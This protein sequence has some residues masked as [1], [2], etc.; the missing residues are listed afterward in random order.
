M[1]PSDSD[2]SLEQRWK[3]EVSTAS[4]KVRSYT[5][6]SWTTLLRSP[7]DS[8]K[9]EPANSGQLFNT[10]TIDKV[11]SEKWPAVTLYF[12]ELLGWLKV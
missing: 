6:V 10:A 1:K 5:A 7:K 4:E 11:R 9:G 2:L 8:R 12:D 3:K